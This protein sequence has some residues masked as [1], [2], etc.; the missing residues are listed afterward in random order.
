MKVQK[1]ENDPEHID[2]ILISGAEK[3]EKIARKKVYQL[4]KL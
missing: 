3:A 2:K 1:L 4:K